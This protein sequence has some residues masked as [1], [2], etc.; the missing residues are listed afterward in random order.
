[1]PALASFARSLRWKHGGVERDVVR[2]P[3]IHVLTCAECGRRSGLRATGWRGYRV[4]DPEYDEE[5]AI[6]FFCPACAEREFGL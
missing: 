2:E 5:P 1:M 6:G 4:D 3:G